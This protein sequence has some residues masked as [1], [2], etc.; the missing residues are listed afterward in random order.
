MENEQ[1]LH[2]KLGIVSVHF[3]HTV[4]SFSPCNYNNISHNLTFTKE[5]M[6]SLLFACLLV[7]R[8]RQ[9]LLHWFPLN[10][11]DGCSMGHSLNYGA[12][13]NRRADPGNCFG[14]PV[15][16]QKYAT[17]AHPHMNYKLPPIITHLQTCFNCKAVAAH[18]VYWFLCLYE[19]CETK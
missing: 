17:L 3:A 14:S 4:P 10:F 11:V 13:P 19:F 12:T 5:A 16:W 15:S 18:R 9:T 8:I 1:A 2:F 7:S 6:F